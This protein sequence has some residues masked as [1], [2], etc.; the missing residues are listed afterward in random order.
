[1]VSCAKKQREIKDMNIQE[2]DFS[3]MIRKSDSARRQSII[4]K[5]LEATKTGTKSIPT[6]VIEQKSI[7]TEQKLAKTTQKKKDKPAIVK[8][9][10]KEVVK[11]VKK[12][13]SADK[14]TI[15]GVIYTVQI[16]ALDVADKKYSAIKNVL[17]YNENS[18]IKYGLG[19]F[20]TFREAQNYRNQIITKYKG[21][22]VKALK[23]N[24]PVQIN[25]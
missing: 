2:P 23:N 7:V 12:L 4:D 6:E 19:S 5:N 10:T 15:E 1:M 20:K 14:N 3:E 17:T 13:L 11:P 22:F 9:V 18:L 21:A 16:A 24:I 8:P 25:K